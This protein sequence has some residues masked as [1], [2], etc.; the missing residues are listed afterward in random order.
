VAFD[1]TW[2]IGRISKIDATQL[3]FDAGVFLFVNEDYVIEWSTPEVNK[4]FGYVAGE[5]DGKTLDILI[6]PDKRRTHSGHFKKFFDNP[7][8]RNMGESIKQSVFEGYK[9]DGSTIKVSI[10]IRANAVDGKK[11]AVAMIFPVI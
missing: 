4:L 6:P 7:V 5:L 10:L 8:D 1:K 9:R 11:I 3:A 2:M